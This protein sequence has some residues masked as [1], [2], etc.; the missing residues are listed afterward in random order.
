MIA[1]AGLGYVGLSNALLLAQH[2]EVVA[3]DIVAQRVEALNAGQSPIEDPEVAE[4]LATRPLRF[5]ATLD[6]E[7][8]YRDA[9]YLILP[10]N[11]GHP[12]KVVHS[13][14]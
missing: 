6:A 10:S 1:V 4:F 8:A 9:D 7:A 13:T 11:S 3:V 2:H 14:R 5:T 12:V